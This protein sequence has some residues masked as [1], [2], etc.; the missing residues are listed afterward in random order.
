MNSKRAFDS[1]CG[2]R[3]FGRVSICTMNVG[4]H[5]ALRLFIFRSLSSEATFERGRR[6]AG[7]HIMGRQRLF[8]GVQ[9]N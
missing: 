1:G 7:K 6:D 8:F 9:L 5:P 3:A 4:C 2:L